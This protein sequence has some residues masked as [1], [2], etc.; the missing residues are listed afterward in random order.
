MRVL[1]QYNTNLYNPCNIDQEARDRVRIVFMTPAT[2][3]FLSFPPR[4]PPPPPSS[5]SFFFLLLLLL[6]PPS[7]SLHSIYTVQYPSLYITLHYNTLLLL[8]FNTFLISC[9]S[10]YLSIY[11]ITSSLQPTPLL[12]ESSSPRLLQSYY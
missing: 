12:L 7:S 9:L 4:S 6:P 2:I 3:S 5:S 8:S 1:N 11:L 10:I